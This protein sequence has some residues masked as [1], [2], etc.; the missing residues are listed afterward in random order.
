MSRHDRA[1]KRENKH[2]ESQR[3]FYLW[4]LGLII[5]GACVVFAILVVVETQPEASD[6]LSG[7]GNVPERGEAELRRLLESNKAPRTAS[8]QKEARAVIA[9]HRKRL[10]ADPESP[11][12]PALLNAMGN[13][14]RQKLNDHN[15]AIQCYEEILLEYPDWVGIRAVFLNLASSYKALG[16]TEYVQ[17]TYQRMMEH[18]PENSQEHRFARKQLGL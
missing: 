15:Q 2:R 4:L 1:L 8:P 18:Y 16:N 17:W 7:T 14:Y 5:A 9:R 10:A 6:R 3:R 13:L 11:D 12:A